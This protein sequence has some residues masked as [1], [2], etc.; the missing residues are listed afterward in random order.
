MQKWLIGIFVLLI[1]S[2]SLIGLFRGEGEVHQI[3]ETGKSSANSND[4]AFTLH[5]NG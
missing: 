4:E 5:T 2:F 3:N 1:I